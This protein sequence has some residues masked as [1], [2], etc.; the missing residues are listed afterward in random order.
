MVSLYDKKATYTQQLRLLEDFARSHPRSAEA[1]FLL[2][3]HYLTTG[4]VNQAVNQWERVLAHR[5]DD[6]L[7]AGL[8][9]ALQPH[10]AG[11]V[12]RLADIAM[13]AATM[14]GKP[15]KLEGT[16]VARPLPGTTITLLFQPEGQVVCRVRQRGA[17]REFMGYAIYEKSTLTLSQDQDNA[18]VGTITW[19]DEDGFNFRLLARWPGD[20]GLAFEKSR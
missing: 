3:Y 15:G 17:S 18:L 14:S 12:D 16:W 11:D 7:S 9:R 6:R 2:A 13:S 8:I 19:H 5:P 20:P 4:Y 10:R 1:H